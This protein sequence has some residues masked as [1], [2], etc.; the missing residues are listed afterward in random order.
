M[1]STSRTPTPVP[2]RA[3]MAIFFLILVPFLTLLGYWRSMIE[4]DLSCQKA[5]VNRALVLFRKAVSLCQCQ[6]IVWSQCQCR[7]LIHTDILM[8]P[9][10]FPHSHSEKVSRSALFLLSPPSLLLLLFFSFFPLVPVN[11][12]PGIDRINIYN[13]RS[14]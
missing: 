8:Q 11:H 9:G 2:L 3:K 7:Y 12:P 4:T 5:A 14:C 10:N 1:S 6:W 13:G